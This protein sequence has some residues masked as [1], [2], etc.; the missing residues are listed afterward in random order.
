M[1]SSLE[2]V[3]KSVL[4]RTTPNREERSHI[5]TLA[6]NLKQK[7]EAA[8]KEAGIEAEIGVEGSVAKDTWLRNKPEID[9]FMRIP[10]TKTSRA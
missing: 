4:T 10:P 8:I 3:C 2:R 6:K 9:I 1:T 7:V 5:I